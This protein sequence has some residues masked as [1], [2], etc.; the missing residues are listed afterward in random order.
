[1]REHIVRDV[2][3][4][5]LTDPDFLRSVQ[6]TPGKA[7]RGYDL[8]PDELA[9]VSASDSGGLGVGRLESRISAATTRPILGDPDECG[10]CNVSPKKC[11]GCPSR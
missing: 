9:A 7:L 5:I 2:I 11:S 4:R 10:C 6:E 8:T 1:M 3:T